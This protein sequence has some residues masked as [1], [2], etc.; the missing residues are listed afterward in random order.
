[1]DAVT[2]FYILT[3]SESIVANCNSG[4]S[5]MAAKFNRVPISYVE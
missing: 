4:F 3:Q 2:E 5:D 1:V